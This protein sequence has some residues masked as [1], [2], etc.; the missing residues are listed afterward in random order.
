LTTGC[1]ILSALGGLCYLTLLT[2]IILGLVKLKRKNIRPPENISREDAPSVSVVIAA[3]DEEENLPATLQSLAQQDYPA[4]S[5]EI[6]VVDD[7]SKDGTARTVREFSTRH[8]SVKLIVQTET[9]C[10][11][12][13]KK[14]ALEKGINA[15]QGEII[16]T[17]DAD[18]T[19]D[20]KWVGELVAEFTPAVGMVAGQARFAQPKNA[21][22][23][24]RLQS[25][26]F[27]SLGYASAG[28][29]TA[30]MPFHCSG[31]SLAFRKRLFED[32]EGWKGFDHLVSGDDELLMAKA[33]QSRWKIVA[34]SS[35]AAIVRTRP[36]STL[37]ELWHQRI[38]WGSKGVYYRFSRRFILSG[39]F[40][41][42]LSLIAGPFIGMATGWWRCWIAWM[43]IKLLLDWIAIRYGSRLFNEK[44]RINEFLLAEIIHPPATV[45][46]A[47]A[48]HFTS[49]KWK[50]QRFRSRSKAG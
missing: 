37:K 3:R 44:F 48:G 14:Q 22:L 12:S 26:D 42:L 23:W 19:H 39:V 49:F 34:A 38:R 2:L 24:Q 41:F 28:L 35:P 16:I 18:C 31:A 17:T 25:L 40:L 6:I 45:L 20:L 30:G 5:I 13:P 50:D 46:F 43:V 9:I 15:A 11:A 21:P 27:Q 32:V 7:R 4:E 1:S 8:P 29:I 36:V 10:G 47:V 33:A